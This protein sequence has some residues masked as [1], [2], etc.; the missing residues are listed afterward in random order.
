MSNAQINNHSG[1][2][3]ILR[4]LVAAIIACACFIHGNASEAPID[5][6]GTPE[7]KGK[8]LSK[9]I[10]SRVP[11]KNYQTKGLLTTRSRSGQRERKR[12]SSTVYTSSSL[13][14]TNVFQIADMD[15]RVRNE[16]LIV[17]NPD[18]PNQYYRSSGKVDVKGQTLIEKI[19]DPFVTI[20]GSGFMMGDMGF[21]FLF[22]PS[23]IVTRHT[24]KSGRKAYILESK[25]ENPEVYSKILTW[26]DKK[27]LGPMK[28]EAYGLDGKL[29]KRFSVGGIREIQG[30]KVVS[31]FDMDDRI[32]GHFSRIE[33]RE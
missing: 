28:A 3:S 11:I 29:L 5:E 14:W 19:N 8:E 17:R 25:Q 24:I 1:I 21:E 20:G 7:Q 6:S 22:W 31:R 26:V 30:Q 23:Q 18:K 2:S 15:G 32:T 9:L 10:L 27:T 16:Y 12:I 33:F 13:T 4:C